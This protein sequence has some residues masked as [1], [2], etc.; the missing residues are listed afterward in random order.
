VKIDE[1]M[2]ILPGPDFPTGGIIQGKSEIKKAYETG[3]GRIIVRSKLRTENVRGGKTH[4]IVDEL[5]F[6]VNKASLVKKMDE[7]RADKKIDG[8]IEVR[9]ETDREG[10]RIVIETRREANVEG[11][12]NFLYKKTD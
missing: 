4:I 9:D 12:I 7:A 8:I 3:R 5:P 6:D 10:L 2:T 11:I 1:L